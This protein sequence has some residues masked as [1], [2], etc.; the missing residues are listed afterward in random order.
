MTDVNGVR[1]LADNGVRPLAH[2][3]MQNRD[4][5]GEGSDP[6]AETPLRVFVAEFLESRVA[7]A[8]L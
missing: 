3:F 8:A 6:A 2:P 5:G 7:A 1:P 4:A